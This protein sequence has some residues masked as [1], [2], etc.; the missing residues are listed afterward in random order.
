MWGPWG[1]PM[2]GFWW[3]FPVMG[4]LLC[5]ALFVIV[6]RAISTGHGVMCLGGHR[7]AGP[8]DRAEMRREIDALREEIRQLKASR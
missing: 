3:I 7:G 4:L 8:D 2:W 6:A 5:L 1:A